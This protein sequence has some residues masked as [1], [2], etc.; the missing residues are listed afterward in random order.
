MSTEMVYRSLAMELTEQWS[1]H[2]LEYELQFQIDGENRP[3]ELANDLADPVYSLRP[4]LRQLVDTLKDLELPAV[5][6]MH[7]ARPLR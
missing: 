5:E 2:S 3:V 7:R 6:F 4:A 1:E